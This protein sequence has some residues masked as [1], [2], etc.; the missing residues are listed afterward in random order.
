MKNYAYFAILLLVLGLSVALAAACSPT[1]SSSSSAPAGG[2]D[3]NDDNDDAS[4]ADD[5]ASPAD[6]DATPPNNFQCSDLGMP[7]VAF[8]DA[9]DS[10]TLDA[11]AADFTVNTTEGPW[12]FKQNWTGCE[13]YLIIQDQP[14]QNNGWP[15]GI[16]ERDNVQFLQDL[17]KN[18]QVLFTVNST[19]DQSQI[20]SKLAALQAKFAPYLA[21]LSQDEQDRWFHRLHYITDEAGY[22]KGWVGKMMISPGWGVGIDRFQKIRYIGSYADPS[23]YDA[24]QQWFAPN[25]SMATNEPIYYN[26]EATRQT[27]MD[28]ENATVVTIFDNTLVSANGAP[29]TIEADVAFPDQATMATFDSVELD[30]TL[31]CVGAGEMGTCPSWDYIVNLQLC[32][33]GD[34]T[35]CPTEFGRWITTYHR[36]GRW[37]HDVSGILPLIADGGTRHFTFYSQNP[38]NVTLTVRLFNAAKPKRPNQSTF[39]FSGGTLGPDYNTQHAPITMN[40]TAGFAVADLAVVVTGHGGDSPGNCAEFC[41]I[42]HHFVV[43]GHDNVIAFPDAGNMEG[44][45]D[46][47][48]EGTVPN[49]YGTWWYGRDGWCP[50]KHVPMSMTDVTSQIIAGAEN[51]F[52]YY[53][54]YDGTDYPNNGP[55]IDLSSWLVLSD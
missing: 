54:Y 1:S 32:D 51:T 10:E 18:V 17:P 23:R 3:D 30:L 12:N 50:G 2:D 49:Q 8:Q 22:I 34:P 37:V 45:M 43:N 7:V 11:L 38:Y 15:I 21:S 16:W 36:I 19:F 9:P 5:D 4:P 41:D 14:A 6:D 27:Q 29:S 39:L 26:Y 33:E 28:G 44:C 24:T 35:S 20:D 53:A 48:D 31:D 47:T 46:M 40:V 55:M 52:D 13:T 25:L 42:E